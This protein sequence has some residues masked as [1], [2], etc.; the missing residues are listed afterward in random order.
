MTC[1]EHTQKHSYANGY[2]NKKQY[3]LHRI[4]YAD[5]IGVDIENLTDI[6]RH[7]C[8]NPRCI[9]PEHLIG[10]TYKDNYQ[11]MIERHRDNVPKGERHYRSTL[12]P[13]I[14][15]EIKNTYIPFNRKYGGVALAKKYNVTN[16]AI[17]DIITGKNW[18]SLDKK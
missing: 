18:K 11:D 4:I 3:K 17:S 6:V 15:E 7:T 13:E 10:G 9:N 16:S 2:R 8:D 5:K 1:I 14:I 12:T